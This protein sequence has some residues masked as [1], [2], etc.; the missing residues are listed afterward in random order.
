MAHLRT[1]DSARLPAPE[2]PAVSSYEPALARITRPSQTL[3]GPVVL[4]GVILLAVSAQVT[5]PL[6]PVPIT[7]QSYVLLTLAALMGW[8]LGGI[9]IAVYIAL[10]LSGLHIFAGGRAGLEVLTGTSGGYLAGFVVAT[11]LVGWLQE[12]WA[13]GRILP[14][15]ATLLAGHLVLMV[16]GA[17]W[18]GLKLGPE[19]AVQRGFIPFLP[20]A[21]LKTLVALATVVV[22]ERLAR[23]IVS[24]KK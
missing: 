3:L 15:A 19:F 10:G 9:T 13:K 18:L 6:E 1:S 23:F 24:S 2:S 7:L 16:I 14:L 21:L 4:L 11:L 20:G 22:V 8:Q 5:I 17:G 12:N